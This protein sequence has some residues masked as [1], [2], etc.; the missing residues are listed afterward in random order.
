MSTPSKSRW[1][2]WAG[3]L[4]ALGLVATIAATY[5]DVFAT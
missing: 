4:V 5:Y 3:A 1:P 2:A